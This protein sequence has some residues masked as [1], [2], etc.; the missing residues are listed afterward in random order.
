MDPDY[1]YQHNY[2]HVMS[3]INGETAQAEGYGDAEAMRRVIEHD[4]LW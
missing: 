2:Q 1:D 3:H 4:N